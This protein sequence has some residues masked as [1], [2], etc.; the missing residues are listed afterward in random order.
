LFVWWV[1]GDNYYKKKLCEWIFLKKFIIFVKLNREMDKINW[2]NFK[3]IATATLVFIPTVF[4]I[5]IIGNWCRNNEDLAM[6][7]LKD[8]SIGMIIF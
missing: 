2:N 5:Y 3:M 8:F 4:I 1:V 7:I 6:E